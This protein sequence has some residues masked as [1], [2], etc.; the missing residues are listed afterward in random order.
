MLGYTDVGATLTRQTEGI[1]SFSSL[2]NLKDVLRR[3]PT[4]AR[5]NLGAKSFSSAWI[6]ACEG[7]ASDKSKHRTQGLPC[8]LSDHIAQNAALLD[9]P[10]NHVFSATKTQ[11]EGQGH[12]RRARCRR[13]WREGEERRPPEPGTGGAKPFRLACGR[14]NAGAV[15]GAARLPAITCDMGRGGGGDGSRSVVVVAVLVV[16]MVLV[17]GCLRGWGEETRED[18]GVSYTTINSSSSDRFYKQPCQ[19]FQ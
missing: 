19:M 5:S 3:S 17:G 16:V 6:E 18:S 11:D 9:M 12:R 13:R 15:K 14:G 8:V 1:S 4:K 2:G 7:F 10:L